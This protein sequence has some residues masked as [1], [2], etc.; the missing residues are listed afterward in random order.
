MNSMFEKLLAYKNTEIGT[1]EDIGALCKRYPVF[2]RPL[3]I[4]LARVYNVLGLSH[5]SVIQDV[6]YTLG[7]A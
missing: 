1:W 2:E 5:I 3:Q 4:S 7:C 6:L